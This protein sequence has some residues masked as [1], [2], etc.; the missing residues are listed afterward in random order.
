ML[1]PCC[2]IPRF[3]QQVWGG[4]NDR[5]SCL[6]SGLLGFHHPTSLQLTQPPLFLNLIFPSLLA[7][8]QSSISALSF[9]ILSVNYSSSELQLLPFLPIY[10]LHE[11]VHP[12]SKL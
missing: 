6:S 1:M 10:N 7:T 8:S 4:Q 9:L 12:L 2:G 3:L 11:P 5:M